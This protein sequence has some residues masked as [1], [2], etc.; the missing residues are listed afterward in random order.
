MVKIEDVLDR[1][2]KTTTG[3]MDVDQ[4][5]VGDQLDEIED[6]IADEQAR[7]DAMEKRLIT[8]FATLE[9]TLA[10]LQNQMASLGLGT[11]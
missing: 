9:A 5:M 4:D 8:R 6:R 10:A 1:M 7:L 11:S 2:L 3:S